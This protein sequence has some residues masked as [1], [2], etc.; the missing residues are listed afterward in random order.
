MLPSNKCYELIK[1]F[2]GLI[3]KAYKDKTGVW[4]IGYGCTHY[5]DGTPVRSGDRITK[6]RAEKLL[7]NIVNNIARQVSQLVTAKLNEHQFDT[8]VSFAFNVGTDIDADSIAEG[9][10]DATLLKLV[11]Q[12]P[13]SPLI[14]AEFSKWNKITVNGKKI[15]LRDLM[16]RRG[17]EADLYFGL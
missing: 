16:W 5:E 13:S 4:T 12:N 8:L 15:V 14:R 1:R 17:V 11:N 6:A 3:L 7:I 10:G 2:E 9:L